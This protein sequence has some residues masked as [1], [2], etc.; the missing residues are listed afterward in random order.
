MPMPEQHVAM[1]PQETLR[2]AQEAVRIMETVLDK[3]EE[4]I[5]PGTFGVRVSPD[6]ALERLLCAVLLTRHRSDDATVP[7]VA[8]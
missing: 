2:A 4:D 1:L 6:P 8:L 5:E 3:Y 7:H